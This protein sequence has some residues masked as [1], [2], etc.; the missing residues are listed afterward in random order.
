MSSPEGKNDNN[1]PND[2]NDSCQHRLVKAQA[3]I[4]RILN[5]FLYVDPPFDIEKEIKKVA[6]ISPPL[7]MARYLHRSQFHLLNYGGRNAFEHG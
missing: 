7:D 1:N 5:I 2:D 3:D 6:S 4:D